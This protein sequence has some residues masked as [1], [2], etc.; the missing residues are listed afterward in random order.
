MKHNQSIPNADEINSLIHSKKPARYTQF[1]K[2][3]HEADIAEALS[4]FP[5]QEQYQFFLNAT[6]ELGV[7]VLEEMTLDQQIELI[8][9]LKVTVAAKYVEKME[10]DDA[11]DG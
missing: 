2:N 9:Q 4:L 7:I 10:P 8:A 3:Y 5:I 6:P 1:F 11:A